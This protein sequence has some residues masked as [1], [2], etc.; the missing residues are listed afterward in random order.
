M[1]GIVGGISKRFKNKDVVESMLAGIK[2]RGPDGQGAFF[3]DKNNVFLGHARLAIIDLSESG[4]QPMSLKSKKTGRMLWITF[5]GEIYNYQEI[6]KELTAHGYEFFSTTDTEVILAAF[7]MWGEECVNKFRGMFVFA[8]FDSE[9]NTFFI[10]RDRFGVKPLYYYQNDENFIFSS[11]LKSI[12]T[13]PDFIKKINPEALSLYFQYGYIASPYTIFENVFKLDKGSFLILKGGVLEIKKYWSSDI[14]FNKEK[15][16]LS[17]SEVEVK[18]EEILLESFQYRM[19]ADVDVGVFLSGGIDSSLVAS[20]LQHNSTRKIKTFTVG[21][22]EKEY[23]EAPYAKRIAQYLGT[24]HYE[25]YVSLNDGKKFIHKYGDIFD[26]PFGDSSSIPTLILSEFASTQIKVVLGGDGG[27]ELFA[28]YSKY[29]AIK[30]ILSIPT[31][32]R[33]LA[34][35]F[36]DLLGPNMVSNFFNKINKIFGLEIYSNLSGKLPK[37][38][39]TLRAKSFQEAF[40]LASSYWVGADLKN[41]FINFKPVK[42]QFNKSNDVDYR[43]QMQL[44]DIDKYLTDDILVKTDR[45]TMYHGL[46]GREPFLDQKIWEFVCT[47]DPAL[48]FKKLGSK[49]LLKDI[50]L[51]Y[52]PAELINRPKSGFRPPL[53]SWIKEGWEDYLKDLLSEKNIKKQGIFNPAVISDIVNRFETDGYVNSDKLWLLLAFQLWYFRWME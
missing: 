12:C 6:K 15:T 1:C 27:D 42:N 11:E 16:A 53:H 4:K 45:A 19:V 41:L 52:L 30:K 44:W 18:L 24:D 32:I 21:F 26:E 17:E 31:S 37:L 8:I 40:D 35:D 13:F 14:Y 20:L 43:E 34:A 50:L 39:N 51:K 10:F 29:Q 47:L 33:R 3:D 48:K 49:Y 46:E 38:S 2:H 25:R 36:I 22:Q 7:D 9:A 5:N 23:D 28:G